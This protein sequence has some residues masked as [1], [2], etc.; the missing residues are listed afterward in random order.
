MAIDRI[1]LAALAQ[2]RVLHLLGVAFLSRVAVAATPLALLVALADVYGFGVAGLIDG[3]YTVVLAGLGP[4]RARVL[5]RVGQRA[6]LIAMGTV[7]MCCMALVV[8]AIARVWP[9]PV[10]LALIVAAGLSAPPLNAALRVSWRQAVTGPEALKVVHLADS[11]VEELGFV[12][13][14]ALAGLGFALLAPQ[15]TYRLAVL[16]VGA[17]VVLYLSAAWRYRLGERPAPDSGA[18]GDGAGTAERRARRW[19]GPL[20]EPPMVPILA[21]LLVMGFMFGG[22][23]VFIPAYTLHLGMLGW[24]GPIIALISVGGVT[25]G[26]VYGALHW[27]ASLWTR[28]RLLATGFV[29]PC[30]MLAFADRP[31]LLGALL[32]LAGLFVTPLFG[33]AFLLVDSAISPHTRHEASAWVGASTDLANGVSAIAIGALVARAQWR[34]ALLVLSAAALVCLVLIRVWRVPRTAPAEIADR[35]AAP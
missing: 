7:A 14:P 30:C 32:L 18:G 33:T 23:G 15:V 31:W 6:A 12:I 1:G 10:T 20:G 29:I 2:R 26:I 21:P 13:G 17:S 4:L 25:G 5:D 35:V 19:L 22:L 24:S 34:P 8:V 28:H 16:G 27:E 11:I 3:S 9:W